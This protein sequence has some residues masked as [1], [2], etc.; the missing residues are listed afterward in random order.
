M[1]SASMNSASMNGSSMS[2]AILTL[3][4]S[5]IYG[6]FSAQK[7]RCERERRVWA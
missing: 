4:L 6:A 5:T 7:G 1:N 3:G 2:K